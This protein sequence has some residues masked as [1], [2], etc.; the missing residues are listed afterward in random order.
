VNCEKIG[1]LINAL[2]KEKNMTQKQVADL[3]NISD[4][5]ISKWERGLGCPD[6]S[7]LPE[8]A[9]IL[10][11]NIEEILLGK[12][13]LNDTVGGNMK[14]LQLHICPQC[15]N[16]ITATGDANISCCGKRLEPLVAEKAQEKHLLTIEPVEDEM[17]VS[18]SHEMKK[19]HY[20]SFVAYVTGDRVIIV[21]QYPEWDLQFRFPKFGHGKLY[22]YCSNHGLFSQ[23]I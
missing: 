9:Q 4:K 6:V 19:E 17:Y 20:I 3:M 8:L 11:V 18:S 14:K 2:R 15:S 5:T 1:K 16:L 7:L 12:M 10:G 13:V 21:K 23:L 22:F